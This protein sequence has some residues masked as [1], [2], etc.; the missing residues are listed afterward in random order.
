M[1]N[2]LAERNTRDKENGVI[3]PSVLHVKR[4]DLTSLL[5][6]KDAINEI[7]SEGKRRN[8]KLCVAIR[9]PD[10]WACEAIEKLVC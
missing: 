8:H 4:K 5:G 10:R 6:K 9:G 2:E 1:F 3:S 7:I